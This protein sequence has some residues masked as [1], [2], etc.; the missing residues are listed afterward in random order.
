MSVAGAELELQRWLD[1]LAIQD[2]IH[3]YSDAMTRADWAE[4]ERVFVPDAV[5]E[6]PVMGVRYES[7]AALLEV[8]RETSTSDF[9]IQTPHAPVITLTGSDEAQATTTVHTLMRGHGADHTAYGAKGAAINFEEFGIF[10]DDVARIAGEWKFTHRLLVP[11]CVGTGS[12]TGDVVTPRSGL[13]R[14]R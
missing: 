13:L 12:V 14:N 6:S 11:I 5:F 4:C 7:R 2:L 3:R 9:F 10:F 8:L 1:R